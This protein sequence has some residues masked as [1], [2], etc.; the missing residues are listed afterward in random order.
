MSR[1]ITPGTLS[2]LSCGIR[3]P[4]R[5]TSAAGG[6]RLDGPVQYQ[7]PAG[8]IPANGY[9]VIAASSTAFQ[10]W[11]G[12]AANGQWAAGR[13]KNSGDRILLGDP[14]LAVVDDVD[15]APGFPWPTGAAGAGPSMELISPGLENDTGGA[16]RNSTASPSPQTPGAAN[17]ALSVL[18]PPQVSQVQHT[19][20][21]PAAAQNV[22]I[23]AKLEDRNVSPPPC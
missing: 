21:T 18:A 19:P 8:M 22:V 23:S 10:S 14:A 20:V 4:L 2:S 6:W 15:Y 1:W 9:R 3:A 16:W 11:F 7:F 12:F 5:R 17:T 13:L